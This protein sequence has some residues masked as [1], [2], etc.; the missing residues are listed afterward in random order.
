MK[1]AAAEPSA[2]V[3]K[4]LLEKA[5]IIATMQPAMALSVE[6]VLLNI[7]GNVIAANTE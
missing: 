3:S 1:T 7:A 5:N 2:T 6:P 4:L